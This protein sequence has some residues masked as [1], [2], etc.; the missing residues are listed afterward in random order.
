[1]SGFINN[2]VAQVPVAA[3][4]ELI[5][6]DTQNSAGE[7][8]ESGCFNLLTLA[9]L[10]QQLGVTV[11]KTPVNGTRYYTNV[12]VGAQQQFTGIACKIG[13][14]GGTDKFIF[15]LHDSTGVLVATTSL[16]GVTVGTA[17]TWQKIAFSTPYLAAA[18]TYWI[19]VQLNGT[20]A[21][22]AVLDAPG[23]GSI[24]QYSGSATGTFGT[25]ASIT[26]PTT[27]TADLAPAAVLYQ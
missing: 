4:N 7:N 26:P 3:G 17:N 21:R 2:G 6:M 14:V 16:S 19:A 5:N 11:D 10:L 22:L 8:P 20:T 1:M 27:Y 25:S 12:I 15:E 18:G 9:L 13:S 24:G 23:L